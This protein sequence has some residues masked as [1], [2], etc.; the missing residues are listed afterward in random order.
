MPLTVTDC[1]LQPHWH[2]GI[3]LARSYVGI[4]A[5]VRGWLHWGV[6]RLDRWKWKRYMFMLAVM[7]G[8]RLWDWAWLYRPVRDKTV[9]VRA[10]EVSEVMAVLGR[11]KPM[12][13]GVV[14]II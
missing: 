8:N 9:R 7:V 14:E 1:L 10:E 3:T 13:S 2:S 4:D 5:V 12:R 6:V 11:L